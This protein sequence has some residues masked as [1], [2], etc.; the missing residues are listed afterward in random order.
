MG[1]TRPASESVR[2]ITGM[3]GA[4]GGTRNVPSRPPQRPLVALVGRFLVAGRGTRKES[5][6][7]ACQGPEARGGMWRP[8]ACKPGHRRRVSVRGAMAPGLPAQ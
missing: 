8:L 2:D 1:Y 5:Y 4:W 7:Q 3:G 6:A